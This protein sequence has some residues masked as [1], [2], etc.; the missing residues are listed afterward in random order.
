MAVTL[1]QSVHCPNNTE[2]MESSTKQELSA[3]L[4]TAL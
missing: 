4:S 2:T 3:T 1:T